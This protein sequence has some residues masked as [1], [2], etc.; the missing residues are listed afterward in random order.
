MNLQ[1][2]LNQI[3]P[4]YEEYL[5]LR[6]LWVCFVSLG[7]VLMVVGALAIGAAFITTLTSVVVFG[8]LLLSGGVVQLVNAFLARTWK[9]FFIHLLA[10]LLYLVVGGLMVEHPVQAAEGLTLML[11]AAF[12][13]GGAMR[14]IYTLM[15]PFAGR[16]WVIMNGF[17]SVLLGISIWR[18]WPE[19][20]LWVI[21]LFIGID[22]VFNGWLWVMLGLMVKS[23]AP[24]SR[25]TETDASASLLSTP[26]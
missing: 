12:L 11:A 5:R 13:L 2:E 3:N 4:R 19:S 8:I 1:E 24:A 6:K 20:S 21:G 18:Q 10:G 7:I 9:G 23:P 26:N 15:Q 16:G 22:L 25:H 17:I 14:V